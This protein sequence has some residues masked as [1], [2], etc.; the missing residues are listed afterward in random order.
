MKD[1]SI[2]IRKKT[3]QI[4]F[5]K[6]KELSP[7]SCGECDHPAVEKPEI[8]IKKCLSIDDLIDTTIHETIHAALP[9]LDEEEVE[10]GSTFAARSL[11]KKINKKKLSLN[12]D[13]LFYFI[14]YSI[15]KSLCDAYSYLMGK[16]IDYASEIVAKVLVKSGLRHSLSKYYQDDD[17]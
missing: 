10:R 3:W 1:F 7:Y 4:R 5:V 17:I 15:F 2:K 9:Y 11:L 8:W 12:D 16:E 6:N 13:C 14:K